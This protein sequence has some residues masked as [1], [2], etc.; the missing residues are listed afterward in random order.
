[1]TRVVVLALAAVAVVEAYALIRLDR[2]D[3]LVASGVA[4]AAALLA[5]RAVMARVRRPASDHAGVGEREAALRR[6]AAKTQSLIAWSES[7]RS[8]WDRR[9]R[10]MLARQFELATGH[11]KARN[12]RAF[13][14]TGEMLF[15]A[16]L[17]QWVDPENISRTGAH[18][19]G[20]GRAA[21]DEILRR[22]ERV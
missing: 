2:D 7:T 18:E 12:P 11:R 8:D 10:P 21:L 19:P 14:A 4:L 22:L 20:P 16:E 15:G 5:V 9:L 17:W 6:W 3:V 1:M 13:Q